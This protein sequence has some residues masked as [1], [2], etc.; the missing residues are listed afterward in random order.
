MS[1]QNNKILLEAWGV[2]IYIEDVKY[3]QAYFQ[4]NFLINAA[5]EYLRMWHLLEGGVYQRAAFISCFPSKMRH[6]LEGSV[7][8]RLTFK[9]GNT[10]IS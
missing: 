5:F 10:V 1:I 8:K 9:R 2:K 6:L 4:V 7:Y 3:D